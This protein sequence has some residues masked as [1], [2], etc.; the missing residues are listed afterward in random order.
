MFQSI[1]FVLLV[2]EFELS[3]STQADRANDRVLSKLFLII[4]MPGDPVFS[5]AVIIDQDGIECHSSKWFN[6]LLDRE[7]FRSPWFG[8]HVDAGI[9]IRFSGVSVPGLQ[10]GHKAFLAVE[11]DGVLGPFNLILQVEK[12]AVRGF[13]GKKLGMIVKVG[14]GKIELFDFFRKEGLLAH[15]WWGSRKRKRV[16][17]SSID[18]L[19]V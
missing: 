15:G 5:V 3:L 1:G 8:V 13:L 7:Q 14:I 17:G 18:R 4:A 9:G 19:S 10:A 6:R 11:A 16:L 2:P 12:Q